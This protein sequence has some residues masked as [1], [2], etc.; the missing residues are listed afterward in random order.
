MT[1]FGTFQLSRYPARDRE[2]LQAWNSADLLLLEAA[3]DAS[4]NPRLTLVA[5][6]EQGALSVAFGPAALWTDS[7]LAA[8]A[9]T[10]NCAT[11]RRTAPAI[12]WST[13]PLPPDIQTVLLRV[14]KQLGY[15]EYQLARLAALL[16]AGSKVHAAGM[17]KH[18]SPHTASLL[19]RYIG[20]TERHRG[21]RRARLFTSTRD[22]RPAA[23]LD[24]QC[25]HHCAEL[26]ADLV[27]GAN[28]FS[29]GRTDPGS[30]LLLLQLAELEPSDRVV[31]L[32]CGNGVLGLAAWQAGL[33]LQILFCDES[34]MAID[35]ARTNAN[36]LFPEATENFEFHHGDGLLGLEGNAGL[37][38]CNPPFHL[39]HT[40]DEFAGQR[41]VLQCA[42]FLRPGGQLLLV[43]NRH[44]HY[45]AL[46][47][48]RFSAVRQLTPN[49][50]YTLLLATR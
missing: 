43:G 5:N 39:G 7:A 36:N 22:A 21:Q 2:P 24:G 41:L 46:L 42:D 10:D 16:P 37:V 38:L 3:H 14:P 28:V 13:A 40:V 50:R 27:S 47:A 9:V 20:P 29:P 8:R 31:D 12:V 6:D 23:S 44:L 49:P 18:L 35:S 34:A 45:R 48:K 15:F 33:G 1:P 32:A 26:G 17:D 19:E 4:V 25:R 11:N 30:R